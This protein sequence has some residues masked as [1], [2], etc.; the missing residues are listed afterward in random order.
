MP[1]HVEHIIPLAV[2][3]TSAKEN[4]WLACTLSNGYKGTRTHCTDPETGE[5]ALLFTP[6]GQVWSEHFRWSDDSVE[7]IG[8]TPCGRATVVALKLN[9]ES[10]TRAL[11]RCVLAG[12]HPP[13]S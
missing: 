12:W 7:I 10:L 8:L 1:M 6:R 13:T 2:G 4:L 5:E 11:H 9:N 3:G